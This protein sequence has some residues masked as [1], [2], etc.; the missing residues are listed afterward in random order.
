M[1]RRYILPCEIGDTVWRVKDGHAERGVV[2]S[3]TIEGDDHLLRVVVEFP[4]VCL[5]IR[6]DLIGK[7]YYLRWDSIPPER[8]KRRDFNR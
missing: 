1:K 4:R 2:E 5:S 8:I 7:E 6:A 3:F